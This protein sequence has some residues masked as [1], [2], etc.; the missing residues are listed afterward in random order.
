MVV[1]NNYLSVKNGILI[2]NLFLLLLSYAVRGEEVLS[3]RLSVS[4]QEIPLKQAL[5]E[6]AK[7]AG[8]EWSYNASILDAD[9][10]VSLSARDWTV[11]ETLRELLGDGYAYKSSGRYLILKKQKPPKSELSGVV[12]DP[13]TGERLANV[14]VYDRKTLR[15]TTT[16]SSGYYRLKV[17]KKGRGGGGPAWLSRYRVAS[18]FPDTAVPE[19]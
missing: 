9:R 8:F 5:D 4:F 7:L 12:R 10:R 11:R 2:I 6:V 16:D 19:N 18:E 1:A 3:R 15:A 13:K 14:T 17:K